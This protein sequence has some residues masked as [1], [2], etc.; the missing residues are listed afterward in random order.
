MTS[1]VGLIIPSSNR[2]VEQEMARFFPPGVTLHVARLRMTG[3]HHVALDQ[4]LPRVEEATRTLTD[5]RCDVVAFHCTATSMEEGMAGEERVLAAVTRAGAPRATTTATAIR[6]AFDALEARRIVLVT[7]YSQKTTSEEAEFLHAAGCEVLHA[8]GHALAGS[9][10]YCA[11]PP[12]FWRDSTLQAARREADAYLVSCANIA[13]MSVIDELE[14]QLAAPVITSNQ[15]VLWDALV[16]IGH[17]D[18]SRCPGRL[19]KTDVGRV[20]RRRNPPLA[21]VGT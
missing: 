2:M 8:V 12:A 1:R 21:E 5:A 18:V 7:P 20:S 3:P 19:F 17:A 10:A 4:L 6:R 14:R 13:A 16:R 11:A 15:A 9:D